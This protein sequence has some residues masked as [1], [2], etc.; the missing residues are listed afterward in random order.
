MTPAL[1]LLMPLTQ[2]KRQTKEVV[3]GRTVYRQS[4]PQCGS[5]ALFLV[6][7]G[8]WLKLT[9]GI[10]LGILNHAGKWGLSDE[11]ESTCSVLMVWHGRN[12][13]LQLLKSGNCILVVS[14]DSPVTF[15]VC[16]SRASSAPSI[17]CQFWSRM[18]FVFFSFIRKLIFLKMTS[19]EA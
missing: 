4:S 6:C 18:S 9:W 1:P 11:P 13:F 12:Q 7:L 5:Q 2:Q 16:A 17:L 8:F 3:L 10:K 14:Q 15:I 19:G